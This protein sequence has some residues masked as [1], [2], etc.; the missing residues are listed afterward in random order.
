MYP[1]V[2][3]VFLDEGIHKKKNNQ[4]VFVFWSFKIIYLFIYMF[5]SVDQFEKMILAW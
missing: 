2:P 4:K 1:V 5:G 3:V